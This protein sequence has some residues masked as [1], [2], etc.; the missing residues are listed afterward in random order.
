[1]NRTFGVDPVVVAADVIVKLLKRLR[2][3]DGSYSYLDFSRRVVQD[4]MSLTFAYWVLWFSPHHKDKPSGNE[5]PFIEMEE[6]E[7][8]SKVFI[9]NLVNRITEGRLL[10]L[11]EPWDIK[12]CLYK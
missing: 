8:L 6:L 5:P 10:D 9:C 7:Q 1:M 12:Q 11:S 2:D 4:E 3:K